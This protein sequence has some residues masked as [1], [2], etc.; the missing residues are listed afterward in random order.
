[1]VLQAGR[2]RTDIGL[3][4]DVGMEWDGCGDGMGYLAACDSVIENVLPLPYLRF[5]Y[6]RNE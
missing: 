4:W 6:F 5:D 2:G 1:V 3:G